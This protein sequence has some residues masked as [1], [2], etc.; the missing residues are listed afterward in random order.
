VL[1]VHAQELVLPSFYF[2]AEGLFEAQALVFPLLR[3]LAELV[4]QFGLVGILH[5]ARAH[6]Q[7]ERSGLD[8]PSVK[9]GERVLYH[10]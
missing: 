6:A 7:G 4:D 10:D 2:P 1:G 3:L 9:L 8:G 5:Q